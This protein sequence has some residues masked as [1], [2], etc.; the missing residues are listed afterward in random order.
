MGLSSPSGAVDAVPLGPQRR[1]RPVRHVELAEDP[2][3]VRLDGLLA[4]LQAAGDELVRQSL[5]QQAEHL[6]LALREAREW[7]GRRARVEHGAGGA[8]I[9]QRLAPRRRANALGDVL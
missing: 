7:I 3:K 9:E 4:D 8:R 2:R 1:L 6:A 5:D